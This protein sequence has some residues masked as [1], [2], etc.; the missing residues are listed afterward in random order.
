MIVERSS[1]SKVY[2][3]VRSRI[4]NGWVVST[5]RLTKTVYVCIVEFC[6]RRSL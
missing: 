5:V 6:L 1:G 4:A 3:D 2:G